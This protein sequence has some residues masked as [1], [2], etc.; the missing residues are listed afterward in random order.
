MTSAVDKSGVSRRD[1]IK[2]W[3]AFATVAL[4]GGSQP[5]FAQNAKRTFVLVHG[6][7][8]GGWVWREVAVALRAAGHTVTT[9]TNTGLGERKHLLSDKVDLETHVEDIVSHIEMEDLRN[10]DLVGWSYGGMVTTGVLARIKDRIRSMIYLDAFVPEDGKALVDYAD[11]DTKALLDKSKMAGQPLPPIPFEAFGVKD[12]EVIK[13]AGPRLALQP[14]R[15][16]YQ[17]VS[18]LKSRPDIPHTYVR[19]LGFNPSPFIYFYEEMK[20]DP[21]VKTIEL[22]GSHLCMLT[23]PKAVIDILLNTV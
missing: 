6:A 3:S 8:H 2:I 13:F 19:A 21:K 23:E 16:F 9:P 14:W 4:A 7:W 1:G 18:A 17:P 5:V 22:Q 12:P 15:T 10:I 20:K 11:A